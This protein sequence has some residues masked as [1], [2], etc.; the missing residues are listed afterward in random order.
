MTATLSIISYI[1]L[2]GFLGWGAVSLSR[3]AAA[4]RALREEAIAAA[5]ADLRLQLDEQKAEA[6]RQADLARAEQGQLSARI[7]QLE[8]HLRMIGLDVTVLDDGFWANKA[9]GRL[10]LSIDSTATEGEPD[11]E[12]DMIVMVARRLAP[13][14]TVH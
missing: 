14:A 7:R 9:V 3:L 4:T 12:N 6:T 10:K 8:E 5:V 13:T 1:L 11:R 2:G